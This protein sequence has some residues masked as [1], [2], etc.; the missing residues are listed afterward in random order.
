MGLITVPLNDDQESLVVPELENIP[1]CI[2]AEVNAILHQPV[3][4]P[5]E[6]QLSTNLPADSSNQFLTYVLMHFTAQTEKCVVTA[7]SYNISVR[8]SCKQQFDLPC[9]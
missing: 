5:Y 2:S 7:L 8:L 6:V 4:S 3:E 1:D 9:S